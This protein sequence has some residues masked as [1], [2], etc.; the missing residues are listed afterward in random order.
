MNKIIYLVGML[1]MISLVSCEDF[2]DAPAE[3]SYKDEDVYSSYTLAKGAVTAIKFAFTEQ[4]SHRSRYIPYYGLNTDCERFISTDNGS[5]K[6]ELAGYCATSTNSQM[7]SYKN[8]WANMYEG[9]ERANLCLEGLKAYGD[10]ENDEKMAYL[11]G[12]TLTL[13][14]IMYAEL[15]KAWGDIPARFESVNT[16][17]TYVKKSNRDVIYKQLLAD[18]LEAEQY[19]P[20]AN[21]SDLT[22]TTENVSKDF[23]KGFRARLALNAGG[24]SQRPNE[25]TPRLSMDDELSQ[26]LMMAIA[27]EECMSVV[28]K[29]SSGLA[30]DFETI[31]KNNCSDVIAAGSESLWEIP[32]GSGRGRILSAYCIPHASIDQYTGTA[33]SGAVGPTINLWYD[34]DVKDIRRD[35]TIAPYEWDVADPITGMAQQKVSGIGK[36]HFGKFRYEWTNREITTSDDGINKIYMRY[37]EVLLMA[38]EAVNY[39]DGPEAAK[40][41]LRMVRERAFKVEDHS[42]KVDNYL[43]AISSKEDMLAAIQNEHKFEFAGE[44]VRKEALIRWNKLGSSLKETKS[45]MFALLDRTTGNYEDVTFDYTDVPETVYYKINGDDNES[46]IFY[47]LNRNELDDPGEGYESKDMISRESFDDLDDY[48]E[49]YFV[50]DPDTKQ[51]WPI[52]RTFIEKSNGTLWNDYGY[53]D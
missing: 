38:A 49:W 28:Q 35:V 46:L 14:A 22:K 50:N 17:T 29:A 39:I 41:Y 10:L 30:G 1:M 36:W 6:A 53:E 5:G 21:E 32:F 11:Y 40:P 31:F 3:S 43:A 19:V 47:G 26:D 45:R 16:E 7:N 23:I 44:M 48:M 33:Q 13:R 20:W 52:W 2:L 12:E 27:K 4:N 9:I 42:E 25:A 51:F 24:Y 18:L 37:A 15:L 8:V 34:Y